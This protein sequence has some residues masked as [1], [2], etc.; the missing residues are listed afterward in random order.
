VNEADLPFK[1]YP[2]M[3]P[4]NAMKVESPQEFNRYVD[5]LAEAADIHIKDLGS[6]TEAIRKRYD[7]FHEAGCR[8][9]D[10]GIEVPRA[11]AYSN[12]WSSVCWVVPASNAVNTSTPRFLNASTRACRIESSSK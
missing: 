7:F 3:R 4:D 10:H 2:A 5:R 12:C 6:F 11:A 8:L 9:S 1:M